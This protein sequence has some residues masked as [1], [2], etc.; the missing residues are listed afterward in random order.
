M[1]F[2][3]DISQRAV[4]SPLL[5]SSATLIQLTK[6]IRNT[7]RNIVGGHILLI[8]NYMTSPLMELLLCC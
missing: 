8:P 3:H 1:S 5:S 2:L 7:L 4:D 6:N